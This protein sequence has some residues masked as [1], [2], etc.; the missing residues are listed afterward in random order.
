MDL[1]E[2]DGV[3]QSLADYDVVYLS[4]ITLSILNPAARTKIVC[5]RSSARASRVP[6]LRSIPI[7]APVAGQ[8]CEHRAEGIS[9]KPLLSA[10]IV[11]AS[12]E[13]LLPLY[14]GRNR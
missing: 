12:T 10:D 5:A 3:L 6:A 9:R 11:L 8:T 7:F 2:T 14:P 4:A 13:D 1:P